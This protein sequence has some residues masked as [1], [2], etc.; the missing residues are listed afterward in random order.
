MPVAVGQRPEAQ[1]A[2]QN[3]MVRVVRALPGEQREI[4][5]KAW[6]YRI[7]HNESLRILVARR[8]HA[9]LD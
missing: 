6:L 5:L 7:A 9:A 8:S 2:L 4:A 3:T 1:D